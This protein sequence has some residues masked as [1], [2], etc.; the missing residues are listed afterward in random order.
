MQDKFLKYFDRE[1]P[2]Y[3][4][5]EYHAFRD[6]HFVGRELAKNRLGLQQT[7]ETMNSYFLEGVK[8][9]YDFEHTSRPSLLVPHNEKAPENN[10]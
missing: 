9:G 8:A 7:K 1:D 3:Y 6:G 5:F 10:N 2:N 4:S